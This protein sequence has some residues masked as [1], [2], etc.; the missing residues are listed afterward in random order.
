MTDYTNT[1]SSIHIPTSL[2]ILFFSL[3]FLNIYF[4]KKLKISRYIEEYFP[5]YPFTFGSLSN[6]LVFSFIAATYDRDVFLEVVSIILGIGI[7]L[8]YMYNIYVD[9]YEKKLGY[10]WFCILSVFIVDYLLFTL[11][12]NKTIA[13]VLF[14]LQNLI[15]MLYETNKYPPA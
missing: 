10:K 6:L 1:M 15:S 11:I 13:Y 5:S 9:A 2:K 12:P 3:L 4:Y 7:C 8:S 14:L